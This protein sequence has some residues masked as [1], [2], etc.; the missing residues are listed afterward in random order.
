M[1]AVITKSAGI[2][3]KAQAIVLYDGA[4]EFCQRGILL[5]S[6]LDWLHRFH[7]Q[8]ARD[9][10]HLPKSFVPLD[11]EAMLEE[12][13][14]LSPDRR[15][16]FRGFEAVRWIVGGLPLL[17]FLWPFLFIPGVPQAGRKLYI[18][19]A[20][21]RFDLVPCTHNQCAIRRHPS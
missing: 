16:V 21:N 18:W 4:C 7:P 13:H 8:N 14:L 17:W 19:V 15:Q 20:K 2:G 6:R 1:R 5:M 10:E 11:P 3:S 9:V 12:M